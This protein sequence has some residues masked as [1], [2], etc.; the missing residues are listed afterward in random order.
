MY[1]KK[2]PKDKTRR[3]YLQKLEGLVLKKDKREIKFDVEIPK[4]LSSQKR[5]GN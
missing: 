1:Y 2:I 4:R 3:E 5:E